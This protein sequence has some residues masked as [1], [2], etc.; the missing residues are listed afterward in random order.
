MRPI[1]NSSL[2]YYILKIITKIIFFKELT[3]CMYVGRMTHDD[4]AI[5]Y[6]VRGISYDEVGISYDEVGISYDRLGISN[7]SK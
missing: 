2:V 7:R 6:D 5:S 4:L 3:S 1:D